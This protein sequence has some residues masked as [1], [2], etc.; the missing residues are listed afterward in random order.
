MDEQDTIT[1]YGRYSRD[2]ISEDVARILLGEKLGR[3]E[4]EKESFE[5]AMERNTS[6]CLTGSDGE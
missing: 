4:E 5:A 1:V 3:I 6:E 2:K